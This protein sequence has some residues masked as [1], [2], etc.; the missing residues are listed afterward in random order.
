MATLSVITIKI[1][2][3]CHT[4]HKD[5]PGLAIPRHLVQSFPAP[6]DHCPGNLPEDI[7]INLLDMK[8]LVIMIMTSDIKTIAHATSLKISLI[9]CETT[10]NL[11]DCQANLRR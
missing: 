8:A 10:S 2:D 9:D 4:E 5:L 1:V 11:D 7:D 3:Y 6:S